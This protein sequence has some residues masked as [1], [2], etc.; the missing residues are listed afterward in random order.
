MC[1][2]GADA[3]QVLSVQVAVDGE[4]ARREVGG[5]EGGAGVLHGVRRAARRVWRGLAAHRHQGVGVEA[6]VVLPVRDAGDVGRACAHTVVHP[7]GVG[8]EG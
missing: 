2:V 6:D 7:A 3:A 4:L 5:G 1:Q 8:G